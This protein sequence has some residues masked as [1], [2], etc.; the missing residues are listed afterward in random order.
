MCWSLPKSF[1]HNMNTLCREKLPLLTHCS[2]V[3]Q[4]CRGLLFFPPDDDV[5]TRTTINNSSGQNSDFTKTIRQNF[6]DSIAR[7]TIRFAANYL[8]AS[9]PCFACLHTD[10]SA[11]VKE[12]TLHLFRESFTST[13]QRV[14]LHI[15]YVNIELGQVQKNAPLLERTCTTACHHYS[16]PITCRNTANY[17]PSEH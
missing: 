2:N 12:Y 6:C 15:I 16:S 3:R 4:H 11:E 5:V 14:S 10:A 8:T 1:E 13:S 17:F 9:L 7:R